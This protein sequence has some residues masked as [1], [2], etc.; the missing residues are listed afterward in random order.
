[1]CVCALASSSAHKRELLQGEGL[2]SQGQVKAWRPVALNALVNCLTG[3]DTAFR[4]REGQRGMGVGGWRTS[5]YS[6]GEKVGGK[7]HPTCRGVVGG[8]NVEAK[9]PCGLA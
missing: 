1:M 2:S 7:T 9:P 8:L 6:L 3:P 4:I 5:C